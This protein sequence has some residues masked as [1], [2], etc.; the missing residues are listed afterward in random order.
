MTWTPPADP[1]LSVAGIDAVV[2]GLRDPDSRD[3][4]VAYL[5]EITDPGL[6]YVIACRVGSRHDKPLVGAPAEGHRNFIRN[7][8]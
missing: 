2:A 3:D 6:L 1:S 4:A 7:R 8:V 5:D